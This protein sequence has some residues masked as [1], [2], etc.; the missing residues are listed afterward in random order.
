MQDDRDF[1]QGAMQ[2]AMEQLPDDQRAEME[3]QLAAQKEEQKQQRESVLQDVA[4][5]LVDYRQEAV[6]SRAACGIEQEWEEDEEFYEGID[7]ANRGEEGKVKNQKPAA[8]GGT[9]AR[10]RSDDRKSNVFINITRP[11][12]DAAAARLGDML[13][14]TDDRGWKLKETPLPDQVGNV[15]QEQMMAPTGAPGAN[16][17]AQMQQV[18]AATQQSPGMTPGQMAA[19]GMPAPQ[20]P[21]GGMV[22]MPRTPVQQAIDAAQKEQRRKVANCERQIDDWLVECNYA[23]HNRR[24]FDDA[25]KIGTGIL[26]GPFPIN[27]RV[28]SWVEGQLVKSKGLAPASKWVDHWDCFPDLSAGEFVQN[29][30]Y[31]WERDRLTKKELG[32]LREEVIPVLDQNGQPVIGPD[33]QAI[34]E[35]SYFVDQIN[36]ALREGPSK[37]TP[38]GSVFAEA[39]G[40]R[41][42]YEI[43]YGYCTLDRDDLITLGVE[44]EDDDEPMVS[45]MAVMVNDRV[46]KIVQNP[47]DTDEFPYDYFVWSRRKGLPFG[48]GISRLVRSPQRLLNGATRN[49]SD[50]AALSSGLI[51]FLRRRGL[52]PSDGTWDLHGRKIFWVDDEVKSANDAFGQVQ[53]DPRISELKVII[54]FALSMAE[55]TTGMP[56]LLQGQM[57]NA[58]DTL[59]GQQLATNNANGVLRRLAK[60]YD[61]SVT[62]PHITRY[63]DWGQQ[64]SDDDD[65]KCDALID[66]RGS[67]ALVERHIADQAIA[68]MGAFINDPSYGMSKKS[69]IREWMKSQRLDPE[70]MEM[71]PEE[72]QAA[73]QPP[74]PPYQVQ[75]AQLNADSNQKIAALEG[76]M[77][78]QQTQITADANTRRALAEILSNENISGQ[79]L[80]VRIWEAMNQDRMARDHKVADMAMNSQEA[81]AGRQFQSEQ[82]AADRAA[83]S[84]KNV[85][86]LPPA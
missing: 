6:N 76:Q 45:V 13:L 79:E 64:Y 43:W 69:W 35:P 70:R 39:N 28:N 55:Q 27:K 34:T 23:S 59:G 2:V 58:P 37:C 9:A 57:G 30:R 19:P 61:D 38:S 25:A 68:Q 72:Q 5:V 46:I 47:L 51:M 52:V 84:E 36:E 71:T 11:Y 8:G 26:K 54:D 78:I 67:S 60:Q 73:S 48:R 65:L 21:G 83:K 82:S 53:I 42:P 80:K 24:V 32:K 16:P 22:P 50:N 17:A 85:N 10:G 44:L 86:G 15:P 77:R 56:L 14:P 3:A 12:V 63:Y 4:T 31:H 1:L 40:V 62:E 7:D 29:G 66:A 81:Q 18:Q 20:Q 75:V 49:M 74:P 33:G 41:Q